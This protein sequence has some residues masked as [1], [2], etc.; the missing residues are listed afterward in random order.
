M[1]EQ[2]NEVRDRLALRPRFKLAA[3]PTPLDPLLGEVPGHHGRIMI[4]RDDCTGL[5]MGG[6]KTRK[7][8]WTLGHA[9]D[10]GADA[11]LTASGVQSNHVR[12]TAAAA[13]RAGMAFHAVVAPA[14]PSFPRAHVESGNMLLDM[15]FGAQLHLV[16]DET[17]ADAAL[18]TLAGQV[19][20]QGGRPYLIPLGASD[21]I[22][23]LGYVDCALE[24][25]RQADEAGLDLTHIFLPT[26]SGGTHGGLLAGLRLAGSQVAV[27]GI[28][29]SEPAPAKVA[30]VRASINGVAE[31]LG[32]DLAIPD[33]EIVVHDAY[34]GAGYA[35]PTAEANDWVRRIALSDGLLLDQVY[36]GKAFAGMADL[37]GR[38]RLDGVRDVVFLHTGGTPALFADPRLLRTPEA[39]APEVAELYRAVVAG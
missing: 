1:G 5:A 10:L 15:L 18:A 16:E 25:L 17:L 4:K 30:K 32:V 38:G 27:V 20:A 23:S 21:G 24:L 36:T 35:H 7:L 26:G 34:A 3:L 13:R 28:S 2:A 14:L 37:L 29:V 33:A 6:N 19:G 9:R 8:E 39:D 22:G 11:L 31:V 12:Q